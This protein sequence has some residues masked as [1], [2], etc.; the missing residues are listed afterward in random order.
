MAYKT[1]FNNKDRGL[2]VNGVQVPYQN[3]GSIPPSEPGSCH[4]ICN[5][6]GWI[7][8]AVK[9][10]GWRITCSQTGS[11]GGFEVSVG[12]NIHREL[13]PEV[14]QFDFTVEGVSIIRISHIGMLSSDWGDLIITRVF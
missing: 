6:G 13:L 2:N 5:E 7:K 14:D 12:I 10:K 9:Q 11:C 3:K 8:P 4:H 1:F